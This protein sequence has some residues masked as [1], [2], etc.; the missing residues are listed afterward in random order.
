MSCSFKL[1]W[2]PHLFLGFSY[3]ALEL[4]PNHELYFYY[5]STKRVQ[6]IFH[7]DKSEK[8]LTVALSQYNKEKNRKYIKIR[9]SNLYYYFMW[10]FYFLPLYWDCSF[11]LLSVTSWASLLSVFFQKIFFHKS[12]H[13]CES[14]IFFFSKFLILRMVIFL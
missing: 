2:C 12:F 6:Q 3:S 5:W 10:L 11:Y 8:P 9:K 4:W 1:F 14:L 7:K 13:V